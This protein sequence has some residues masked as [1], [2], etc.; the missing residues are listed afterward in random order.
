MVHAHH[1]TLAVLLARREGTLDALAVRASGRSHSTCTPAVSAEVTW[2]SCKWLGVQ[3]RR[4]VRRSVAQHFFDVVVGC[5]SLEARGERLR[6]A[7]V[8]VADRRDFDP[9]RR[10]ARAR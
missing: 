2:I 3:I 10:R 4:D 1:H 6:L 7:D 8:V 9:G 5:L